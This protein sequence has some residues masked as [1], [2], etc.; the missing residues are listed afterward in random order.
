MTVRAASPALP[1]PA[2]L[3]ETASP[4]PHAL[5]HSAPVM[6]CGSSSRDSTSATDCTDMQVAVAAALSPTLSIRK[7]GKIMEKDVCVV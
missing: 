5:A 1:Q 2:P 4:L 6:S 7:K 3:P